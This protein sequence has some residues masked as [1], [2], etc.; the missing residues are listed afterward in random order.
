MDTNFSKT[1]YDI[2]K[3]IDHTMLKP[4][5]TESQIKN[6]CM[7]AVDNRF[8]SVCVNSVWVPLCSSLL[9]N[10]EVKVCSVIGFP[11][12][13]MSS[14]SKAFETSWCVE[15]GASEID[16]VLQLGFLKNNQ[17]EFVV[18]DIQ[19]V[20]AAAKGKT[21]KVIFET[22]LLS[23]DEKIKACEAS[24]AGGAQFVKTSTGFSTA[25]ATIEDVQ[26]MKR[27]VGNNAKVK[28]SGGIKN[29]AQA[30]AFISAGAERL[31]TSSGVE[32]LK[33]LESKQGY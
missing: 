1:N 22:C 28:A 6:L 25:G 23:H 14:Q 12:G 20:V 19:T 27:I 16:M 18:S 8:Y 31:G 29:L 2:A 9:K 10:S 5:A 24:L 21:V 3:Y 32:I 26:L 13:A 11:L 15:N 33:G 17:F 7:E 30:M 4:E